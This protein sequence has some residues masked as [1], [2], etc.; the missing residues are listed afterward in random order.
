MGVQE[1]KLDMKIILWGCREL[2]GNPTIILGCKDTGWIWKY[3]F[4]GSGEL[5]GNG[6]I[7]MRMQGN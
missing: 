7:I 4:E 5:A 2:N 3:H 6:N 1:D